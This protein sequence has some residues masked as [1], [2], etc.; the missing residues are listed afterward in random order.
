MIKSKKIFSL[1]T[2]FALFSINAEIFSNDYIKITN[3]EY[4]E[5]DP[6]VIV[7]PLNSKNL[8]SSS[9]QHKYSYGKDNFLNAISY[10]FDNGLSWN[11]YQNEILPNED[12]RVLLD[13]RDNKLLFSNDGIAHAAWINTLIKTGFGGIDSIIQV[14]NYKYSTDG[15]INWLE[16]N[17][18]YGRI[19]SNYD[20]TKDFKGL[21]ERLYNLKLFEYNFNTYISYSHHYIHTN[22]KDKFVLFN[23]KTPENKIEIPLPD[24]LNYLGNFDLKIKG[25][26]AH[27]AFLTTRFNLSLE[28][29][30]FNLVSKKIVNQQRI[31]LV[32]FSGTT[33]LPGVY[34]F[35][36]PGIAAERVNPNPL[37]NF[38]GDEIL[39]SWYGNEYD[40]N[41]R[42]RIQKNNIFISKSENG[43]FNE[44]KKVLNDTLHH[45][46]IYD[47]RVNENEVIAIN[48]HKLEGPYETQEE[49]LNY[50]VA[51]NFLFSFDGGESFSTPFE[52]T[53]NYSLIHTNKRNFNY[54][55]GYKNRFSID[56]DNIYLTWVD[57]SS[58]DGN[59][60][61]LFNSFPINFDYNLNDFDY[62]K[63]SI[64][65]AYPNPFSDIIK[66][67]VFSNKLQ[68]I[69]IDIY[70]FKGRYVGQLYNDIITY[71]YNQL[72][73]NVNNIAGGDYFLTC[74]SNDELL[75][76]KIV[77]LK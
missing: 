22:F 20:V 2:F 18:N 33:L 11:R 63:I 21:K 65:N 13:A 58:N 77:K 31:G 59:T 47:L 50:N 9:L 43:K 51:M 6:E 72:E 48:F 62:T 68:N 76:K 61:V 28:Y 42:F 73:L 74:K 75:Y 39:I 23:I 25:N 44:A 54:G 1:L 56:K 12:Y 36:L 46:V 67:R 35:I 14:I 32:N 64:S 40:D 3:S 52:Y 53:N 27:I 55:I 66:L 41:N 60:E 30:E 8:I 10:S 45:Q 34:S 69:T 7:N 5:T 49:R 29:L 17:L 24:S 15:G 4:S 71:G 57:G 37:L 26:S 16:N 38:I 19:K 70:D